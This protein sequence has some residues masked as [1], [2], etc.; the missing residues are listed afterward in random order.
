[1]VLLRTSIVNNFFEKSIANLEIVLN[2]FVYLRYQINS[3]N[4]HLN[5]NQ[6]ELQKTDEQGAQG[7]TE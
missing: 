6:Y 5:F 3:I 4:H 1:M 2:F 7:K